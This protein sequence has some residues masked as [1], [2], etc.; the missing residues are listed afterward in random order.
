M[1]NFVSPGVLGHLAAFRNAFS[2]P[3]ERGRDRSASAGERELGEA[4]NKELSRICSTFVLRR[5]RAINSRFLPPRTETV[6]FC[7]L[8]PL[9]LQIYQRITHSKAVMAAL[10]MSSFGEGLSTPALQCMTVLRKLCSHP[11]LVFSAAINSEEVKSMLEGSDDFQFPESYSESLGHLELSLHSKPNAD[12]SSC[13]I[14][15]RVES[16]LH[17]SDSGKLVVLDQLLSSIRSTNPSDKCVVVSNH[18]TT[19]DLI[20][21][22]CS[23]RG[24]SFVR[25]DGQTKTENRMSIVNAFN[26]TYSTAF[27]FLLSA[28]AGGVGLNLIGGNRMILFDADW[29]PATD[30]QVMAR[31]W[32]DGQKKPV[33]IYRLL[34]MG[35]IEEIIFQRQI[36]KSEFKVHASELAASAESDFR[37]FSNEDLRECFELHAR[38]P[39]CR[40]FELLYLAH[41]G[42]H[43]STSASVSQQRVKLV[44]AANEQ[45]IRAPLDMG[46]W[47][48]SADVQRESGD[49]A[50]SDCLEISDAIRCI[51]S[52][53]S[54]GDTA[55]VVSAAS[56][57][58][59]TSTVASV[60]DDWEKYCA[61]MTDTNDESTAVSSADECTVGFESQ[62]ATTASGSGPNAFWEQIQS[63][64]CLDTE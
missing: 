1:C 34:S 58:E 59:E 22:L 53:S 33:F 13:A 14:A 62:M 9:Q 54:G 44:A 18:T 28:K 39:H 25:L 35:T 41:H 43:I 56:S 30:E 8:S 40:T 57:C 7:G 64:D 16:A 61:A 51:A 42:S 29:N 50:L 5:T 19:L 31:C 32:R 26:S 20:Q 52:R 4:R 23:F 38:V 21:Q 27:V 2:G 37:H 3:I 55:A 11:L 17:I 6:L 45:L 15:E 47:R 36:K 49:K 48:F 46:E 60:D 24:Y 63:L 10:R 12:V